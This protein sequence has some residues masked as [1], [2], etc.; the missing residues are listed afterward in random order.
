LEKLLDESRRHVE[1]LKRQLDDPARSGGESA[2]R[3]AARQRAA[4]ER[5]RR[6]EE[7]VALLPKLEEKRRQQKHPEARERPV[8]V[9]TTD[10]PT[11]VMKMPD[12]GYRPA[13]NVQVAS[14]TESRA[15]LGVS[16]SNAGTDGGQVQP[17]QE[18]V[19]RRTGQPITEHLVDGGYLQLEDVQQA[20]KEGK[21]LYVPPKP[22]RKG[23]V[24]GSQY[25]ARAE[26][27]EALGRWRQRMGSQEGRQVYGLRASTS[28]TIN[29]DLRCCRGL[30]QFTVRGLAKVTCVALWS[31][32]AYN[33]M[34]FG[35]A[36]LS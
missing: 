21:T 28:E 30:C 26:E 23:Q 18:Q 5:Q 20:E 32:L 24:P 33:L 25:Q 34:H 16:V 22:P 35:Q 10:A 1:E 15:I 14:D 12:G 9:S 29:A 2:R 19:Q 6:L 27:S 4:K 31:A 7:A 13:H 3:K 11:P 17:M 36:L 8:R